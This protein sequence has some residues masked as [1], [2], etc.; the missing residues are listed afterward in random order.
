MLTRLRLQLTLLYLLVA[1][2]LVALTGIG[3]Y[4]LIKY[5]VLKEAD[6]ALQYKMASQF[7][8]YGFDMP[9]ELVRAEQNWSGGNSRL[10]AIPTAIQAANLNLPSDDEAQEALQSQ[11]L[12]TPG[13]EA[14]KEHE[15][16][17]SEKEY[18]SQLASIFV[19]PIDANGQSAPNPAQAW[20]PWVQDQA[21]IQTALTKGSDLRTIQLK[22]GSRVRLLTYRTD[23]P[24]GPVLLQVGRTLTDDDRVLGNFVVGMLIMGAASIILLGMGSWW[25]SGRSI[26]PAQRAWDQQQ[27]FVSNASHELRTPLTLIRASAEVALRTDPADEQAGLLKD[28]V[29]EADYMNH[30]V[31]DLLLLSRLDSRRLLLKREMV[32]LPELLEEMRRKMQK[33]ADEKGIRLQVGQAHG[34]VWGDQTRIQ[35]VLLILLDNALRFTPTGGS[36]WLETSARRKTHQISVRDN[37]EGIPAEHLP[38]VFERFY[39]ANP[40]GEG[41]ARSNGLGLSIAKGIVEAQGGQMYI[42]SQVGKETRVII[43]LRAVED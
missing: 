22:S 12:P 2:S 1:M 24:Q 26:L 42:E 5:F 28:I 27:A 34:A 16:E 8:L 9:T 30:L 25:L 4:S 23:Y 20:Q 18:D 3:S 41:P 6:L 43:E 17:G 29:G 33:L 11:N 31:E 15:E 38:H 35:Q 40:T 39:Q 13:G 36:I 14:E 10:V 19:L 37:G 7:R 32:D 21:A